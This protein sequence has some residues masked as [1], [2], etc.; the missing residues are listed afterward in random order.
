MPRNVSIWYRLWM[1]RRCGVHRP[2]QYPGLSGKMDVTLLT[3]ISEGQPLTIL[4]SYAAHKPVIATDVGNCRDLIYGKS[5]DFGS[6]GIL[7]HIMNIEEIAQA[8][9]DMAA[10]EKNASKW[11]KPDTAVLCRNTVWNICRKRT[12]RFTAILLEQYGPE[13]AGGTGKA[14]R[15]AEIK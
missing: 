5:D 7:T 12:G 14:A 15:R 3:S 4:E 10:G 6:A 11:E 1:F 2:S 8:M 13:M 9:L